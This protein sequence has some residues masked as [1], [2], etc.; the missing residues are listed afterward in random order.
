LQ[1][2]QVVFNL[3]GKYY[4]YPQYSYGGFCLKAVIEAFPFE[5]YW[6]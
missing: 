1:S 3:A 6:L 2:E 4:S 5:K